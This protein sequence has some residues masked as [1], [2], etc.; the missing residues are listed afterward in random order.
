M[1]ARACLVARAYCYGLMAGGERGVQHA[2]DLL[3]AEVVRT[4]A[5]LGVSAVGD[6]TADRVRLRPPGSA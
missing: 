5:L 2:H 4:M 6:L 1:G 3:R